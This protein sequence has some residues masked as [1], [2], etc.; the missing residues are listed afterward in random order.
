MRVGGRCGMVGKSLRG[1]F[2]TVGGS[3]GSCGVD[4][5]G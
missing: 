2:E 1:C 5:G 3:D 4:A